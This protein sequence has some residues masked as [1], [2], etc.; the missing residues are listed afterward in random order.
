M[1]NQH[2]ADSPKH[3]SKVDGNALTVSF[4]IV[5]E[6]RDCSAIQRVKSALHGDAC[7]LKP[8]EHSVSVPD[9]YLFDTLGLPGTTR[10]LHILKRKSHVPLPPL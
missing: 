1:L 3:Y 6:E 10:N 4:R 2:E 7:L 5:P 8:L 9:K